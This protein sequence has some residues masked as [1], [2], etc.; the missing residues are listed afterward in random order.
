MELK[1]TSVTLKK[2]L[3]N[4]GHKLFEN[5]SEDL[6]LNIIGIRATSPV[7]NKFNDIICVAWKHKGKWTIKEYEATTLPGLKWL[8][9]PMTQKGCAIL[10]PG[11]YSKSWKLALHRQQYTALCQVGDVDVYRDNNKD[12]VW[13]KMEDT[14]QRGKFGINIH[15]ASRV[16]VLDVVGPYSAGCQVFADPKDFDEFLNIC[17][18][19]KHIWGELFTYTLIDEKN[20][21]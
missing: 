19:S 10:K 5:D 16:R 8:K 3:K 14:V 20:F 4:A 21:N 15:R 12:A 6:N 2:A 7:E 18:A 13:D 17:K 1:I 11:R 9:E